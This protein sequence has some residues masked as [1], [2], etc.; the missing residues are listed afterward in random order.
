MEKGDRSIFE[1]S[2]LWSWE[3][4]F[5]Y[6]T[7]DLRIIVQ[8]MDEE[9]LERLLQLHLQIVSISLKFSSILLG[10]FPS[11]LCIFAYDCQS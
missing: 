7:Y 4:Y 3:K 2:N 10:L 1:V 5:G 6:Q 8:G 11:R 9:E